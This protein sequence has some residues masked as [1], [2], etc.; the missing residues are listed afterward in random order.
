MQEGMKSPPVPISRT[1]IRARG[2]EKSRND[3]IVTKAW[4]ACLL[5][6]SFLQGDKWIVGSSLNAPGR[7]LCV[8]GSKKTV[9]GL[10]GELFRCF[11][12]KN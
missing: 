5:V 10:R 4:F 6:L 12:M 3:A 11:L 8:T 7:A 9:G 2:C 1:Y